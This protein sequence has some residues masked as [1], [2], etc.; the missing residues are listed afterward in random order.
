MKSSSCY[1][2]IFEKVERCPIYVDINGCYEVI[3]KPGPYVERLKAMLQYNIDRNNINRIYQLRKEI[4]IIENGMYGDWEQAYKE[5]KKRGSGGGNS[6]SDANA[7][8][9][10]K[11]KMK[12][13]RPVECKLTASEREEIKEATKKFEEEHGALPKLSRAMVTRNKKDSYT[14]EKIE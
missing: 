4:E 11:Q 10:L 1:G 13:N 14:G 8:T 9:S 7:K 2:C 12:D 6:E 5:D 3:D